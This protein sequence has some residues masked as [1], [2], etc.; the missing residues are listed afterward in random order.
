MT[1]T[2]KASNYKTL[3]LIK[4]LESFLTAITPCLGNLVMAGERNKELSNINRSLF[5]V[6]PALIF[7]DNLYEI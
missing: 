3:I 6:L 5:L 4:S 2:K 1:S 7:F